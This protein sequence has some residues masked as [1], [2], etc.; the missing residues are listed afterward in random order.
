LLVVLPQAAY[1]A[2]LDAAALTWPFALPFSGL[3]LSIALG[4]L[5]FSK[6]WHAHY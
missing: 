1:A 6:L 4:S 3:L 2:T 5:L